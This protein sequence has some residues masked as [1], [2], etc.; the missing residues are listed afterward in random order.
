MLASNHE[1]SD[2]AELMRKAIAIYAVSRESVREFLQRR[3][4]PAQPGVFNMPLTI[5]LE[6]RR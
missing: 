2:G 5:T 6:R 3:V 1:W 4:N